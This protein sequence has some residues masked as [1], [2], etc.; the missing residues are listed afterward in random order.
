MNIFDKFRAKNIDIDTQY[1]KF[2]R[3]KLREWGIRSP[4]DLSGPMKK[5]FYEEVEREWKQI[6]KG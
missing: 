4:N 1:D 5:K 6:N 2:Y 3:R